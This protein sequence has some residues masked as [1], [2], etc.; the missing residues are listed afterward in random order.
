MKKKS[1]RVISVGK[2]GFTLIE[3]LVVIAI[4]G[5]LASI[6]LASL[7]TA[8]KKGR[9]ARRIADMR[10]VQLALELYFSNSNTYPPRNSWANLS[11]DL[12]AGG[13]MSAVPTDPTNN[14]TYAYTYQAT[15]GDAGPTACALVSC[16]GYMMRAVT[17]QTN[18][19]TETVTGVGT[20]TSCTST[21]GPPYNYC[22]R[23]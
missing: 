20:V 10:Q 6:V 8:R 14:A 18:F 1:W 4:I 9:D 23:I 15:R 21:G 16:A 3:L 7:N 12:V 5:L 11:A 2:Q 13:V 22:M 19:M 17:E